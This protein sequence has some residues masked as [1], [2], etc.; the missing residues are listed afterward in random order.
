MPRFCRTN[1]VKKLYYQLSL[2]LF[3]F[4]SSHFSKVK[5]PREKYF[6]EK[7]LHFFRNGLKYFFFT[8][9][10]LDF[11]RKYLSEIVRFN[12][13]NARKFV[14]GGFYVTYSLFNPNQ[15]PSLI[16][17]K[18]NFKLSTQWVLKRILVKILHEC[19]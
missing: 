13:W 15:D 7:F 12:L 4:F 17:L 14:D 2:K 3:A 18:W 6:G 10:K 8:S 19:N 16:A 9:I 11:P 1:S 5:L